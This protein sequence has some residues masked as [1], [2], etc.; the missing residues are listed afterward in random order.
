MYIRLSGA[1]HRF[2]FDDGDLFWDEGGWPD[3]DSELGEGEEFE[4]LSE[5][6]MI[7]GRKIKSMENSNLGFQIKFTDGYEV[8]LGIA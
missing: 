8:F 5:F 4:D 1:Y 7:R 6:L 3:A 2:Y